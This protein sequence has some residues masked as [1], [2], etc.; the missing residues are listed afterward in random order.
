[1]NAVSLGATLR[2]AS[3]LFR[4]KGFEDPAKEAEDLLAQFLGCSRGDLYLKRDETFELHQRAEFFSWVKRR[5]L[6]EPLAYI[7]GQVEFYGCQILVTSAVLIP[8]PETELLV[9]KIVGR[10]KGK[11]LNNKVLLDLCSGSGCIGIALK[12][13]F[14]DLFV[15]LSDISEEAMALAQRSALANLTHVETM[16]GDLLKALPRRRVDILVCNPPYISAADYAQLDIQV[17]DFE[18]SLALCAGASGLEFYEKIAQGLDDLLNPQGMACFEIGYDQG[19][20]VPALF[21]HPGWRK[22]S[23]EKDWAGHDRFFFLEKE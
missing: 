4:E 17:K 8:R 1:M 16:I 23:T 2:E 3:S 12:K 6:G 20:T 18:P 5:L 13:R 9:E 21:T 19:K 22:K 10:L 11:E 14:P 15:C 7:S